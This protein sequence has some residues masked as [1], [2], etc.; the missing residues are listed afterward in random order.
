MI[1]TERLVLR[2]WSETDILPFAEINRDEEV[3]KYFPKKLSYEDTVGFYDRIVREF[4]EYGYGL[5]AV[6]LKQTGEFIGYTGFHRFDF[7][8]GFSPGVE[9]GWR[10]DSRYWNRGYATEAA[11]ACLDYA[12]KKKWF[13]RVYSFTALCNRRSERV[14]Q[15]IGMEYAGTF[16]HPA[17]SDGHWL[18]EHLLY[19][20][21]CKPSADAVK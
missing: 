15:K 1:E 2:E 21:N 13:A 5:Y 10:L 18:K 14:M 16:F 6:E 8:A 17:L 11:R 12:G 19:K 9:I 4:A 20:I 3:M 7:A